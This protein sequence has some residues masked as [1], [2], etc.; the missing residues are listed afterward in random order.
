MSFKLLAW[1]N[2]TDE[3][4]F[5]FCLNFSINVFFLKIIF[6]C[7]SG[8]GGITVL[9]VRT[10]LHQLLFPFAQLVKFNVVAESQY[11]F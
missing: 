9:S 8:V 4:L 2:F 11:F 10:S 5:Y 1:C 3:Y 7:C 6:S